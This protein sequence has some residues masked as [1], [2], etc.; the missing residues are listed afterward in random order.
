MTRSGSLQPLE[1][2]HYFYPILGHQTRLFTVDK[3]VD[4]GLS[5][6]A[7]NLDHFYR[8]TDDA[9]SRQPGASWTLR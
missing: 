7:K 2:F 1:A 3:I 8:S 4:C 9:I 6:I 5:L